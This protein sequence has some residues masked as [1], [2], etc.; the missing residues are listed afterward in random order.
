MCSKSWPQTRNSTGVCN[1]SLSTAVRL[2]SFKGLRPSQNPSSKW[3]LTSLN[4][5]T[6][7]LHSLLFTSHLVSV[8]HW[9]EFCLMET[10]LGRFSK[11][12]SLGGV[13]ARWIISVCVC[14][15]HLGCR[16]EMK[17]TVTRVFKMVATAIK[18]E[19]RSSGWD[20]F[21]HH[22]RSPPAVAFTCL[23]CG[24]TQRL[25][26]CC[27]PLFLH[28]H[29]R[30]HTHPQMHKCYFCCE[31]EILSNQLGFLCGLQIP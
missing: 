20:C 25:A 11:A 18:V 23:S 31:G 10:L 14:P 15:A 28:E 24:L 12:V 1:Y 5:A 7:R 29:Y 6:L 19:E 4:A 30:V 27:E 26:S 17:Q 9:S 2:A 3:Y 16:V 22:S 13:Q 8:T 21:F